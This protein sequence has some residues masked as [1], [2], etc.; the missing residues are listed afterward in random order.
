MNVFNKLSLK[1]KISALVLLCNAFLVFG[2]FLG[3]QKLS[4]P[5]GALTHYY[6]I[7]AAT[8]LLV[9]GFSILIGFKISKSVEAITQEVA[10]NTLN[11]DEVASKIAAGSVDL[12]SAATQQASALQ[13]SVA[14]IDEIGAMIRK[15][16]EAAQKSKDL[17]VKS[18]ESAER[19]QQIV[20]TMLSAMDEISINNAEL[21]NQMHDSNMQLTEITKL[22][23]EISTKTQV[24]NDIVFQTKL[25]S[26][27]AAVEAARA[28]EYGYGFAV[29][30]DEIGK[31]AQ[32]SGSAA[33]EI[34][35]MLQDSV[36]RVEYIIDDTKTKVDKTMVTSKKKINFGVEKARL[37]QDALSEIYTNVACVD[38]LVLEI[39]EA[40]KEQSLGVEQFANAMNQL[41]SVT[42]QNSSVAQSSSA[43]GEQ[44]RQQ[45]ATINSVVKN[46]NAY[47]NGA[48]D[49]TLYKQQS[50]APAT[51][52][53]A[54]L[55][56]N[57]IDKKVL[58]FKKP[59]AE[60][61]P[62]QETPV[63]KKAAGYEGKVPSADDPGFNE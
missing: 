15:N 45:S 27:N 19:G 22:I 16:S 36:G 11:L 4:L 56:S 35:K 10:K 7:F 13:E 33:K 28:G 39:T 54:P 41:E 57:T 24:I 40:S 51:P 29:V 37:C 17:S 6:L 5:E 18:K 61:A 32:R 34:T 53:K 50:P 63:Y 42:G 38:T 25:L 59:V 1:Y 43:A 47:I 14:T 8:S 49:L 48:S 26:F 52:E 23:H 62:S 2:S 12:S 44:L 58:Q 60:P 30:A 20:E 21:S 31:L 9:S 46:L 55:K 3:L